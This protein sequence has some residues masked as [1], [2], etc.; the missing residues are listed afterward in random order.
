FNAPADVGRGEDADPA[1]GAAADAVHPGALKRILYPQGGTATYGY[2]AAELGG[3]SRT[4]DLSVQG[5]PRVFFGAD[6]VVLAEVDG[7]RQGVGV[8]VF[9]WNGLWV[10][11]PQRYTLP[12]NVDLETLSVRAE[13]EFFALSFHSVAPDSRL[14][15]GLFHKQYGRFGQWFMDE[16]LTSL[17]IGAGGQGLVATGE[18]FMVAVTSGGT[19]L[20][21][22][23]DPRAKAW[24]DRSTVVNLDPVAHFALEA[25][26]DYFALASWQESSRRVSLEVLFRDRTTL[27]FERAKLQRSVLDG[28]EWNRDSTPTNFW[29]LGPQY[30][31]STFAVEVTEEEVTYKCEIQ[32]WGTTFESRVVVDRTY[33]VPSETKLP[34]SQS[35]AAGSVVGNAEHLF[36]F[37]GVRWVEGALPVPGGG[38]EDVRFVYGDDVGIVSGP[39]GSALML[40]D[41]FRG[42][43]ALK[44]QNQSTGV[45]IAPSAAGNYFSVDQQVLFRDSA[46]AL[47]PVL[48]L[49]STTVPTSLGNRAPEFFAYEDTDNVFVAPLVNGGVAPDGA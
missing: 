23:W 20:A 41:P 17:P 16:R 43:W 18:D 46:G 31:V 9:S 22:V 25:T 36:R 3:T 44:Q 2:A 33:R 30:A 24:I 35:V 42:Q 32:Q 48:E 28:V 47:V 10:E 21:R 12:E 15:L 45:G 11:A 1:R 27:E 14:F 5:T 26:N 19:F 13:A 39:G 4:L 6:Y 38:T 40:Y 29:A 34:Y 7:L 49:P 37:N 8:R